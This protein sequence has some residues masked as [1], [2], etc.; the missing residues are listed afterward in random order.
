MRSRNYLLALGLI[1]VMSFAAALV[2]GQAPADRRRSD[3]PR[4]D[5]PGG[6]SV[7]FLDL[8]SSALK[9]RGQ[10]SIFLP[11][12]YEKGGD[13]YPVVYFLHGMFNDHTSWTVTRY[14]NLPAK[15]EQL[16]LG[17]NLPEML[18]VHP[19]GDRSFYTN[20]HDGS[21]KYEDFVVREV[22]A[23]IESHYRAKSER[24]F[25]A[26][27]GTS[28]GGYGA[29]KIAMKH[30]DR[31]AAAAAHSPIIFPVSNP[32][33]V[34]REVMSSR[35]FEFFSE[36]FAS[37]YGDPFDQAYYEANDPLYLARQASKDLS[38]YFDYGTADRY[39]DLVH[40]DQGLEKL[41][42]L[43]T[44]AGV[45]HTF[46]VHPGEPHGWALVAAHIDESLGFVARGF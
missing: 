15:I 4:L 45:E 39:N 31:Y 36:V 18:L 32:M 11:P 1:P 21:L 17:G 7:R 12:S 29:L 34:P 22:P 14:G 28:M 13:S 27:A 37:V 8:E 35:R 2:G 23:Y 40:L 38:L 26:L 30:P 20:Y 10:F 6:G 19:N 3:T 9:G 24:R 46:R 33:D 42:R 25:R 16:M 43:L 41:D 5:L 44:E